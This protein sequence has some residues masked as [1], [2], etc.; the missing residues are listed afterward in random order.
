M[1]LSLLTAFVSICVFTCINAASQN[2]LMNILTQ[3]SG[4]VSKGGTVFLEIT[5]C[6]TDPTDSVPIYKL[7]PQISIPKTIASIPETGHTLPEGWIITSNDGSTIRLSNGVDRIPAHVCR[8]ILIAIKGNVVGG[9]STISGNLLF[10]NGESPGSLAG[11]ATKGDNPADNASTST[12]T[13]TK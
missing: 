1:K 2:V 8:T 9:P 10:A 13:I 12:C 4:T 5:I 7:R 6:N 11:S 3:N